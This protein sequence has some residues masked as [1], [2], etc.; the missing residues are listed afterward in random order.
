MR[1]MKY[2]I[3]K[4]GE[5]IKRYDR[6][7]INFYYRMCNRNTSINTNDKKMLNQI[8]VIR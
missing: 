7:S 5:L 8:H 3:C 4:T 2:L 1:G 6:I